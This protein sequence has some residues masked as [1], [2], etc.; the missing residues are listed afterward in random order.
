MSEVFAKP[1]LQLKPKSQSNNEI[2]VTQN[3]TLQADMANP[4]SKTNLLSQ[5]VDDINKSITTDN[6]VIRKLT[7]DLDNMNNYCEKLVESTNR[8]ICI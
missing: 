6:E 5:N 4:L 8:I 3:A 1:K 7:S 2:H